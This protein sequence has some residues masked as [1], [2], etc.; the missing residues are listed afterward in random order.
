MWVVQVD[1]RC[2]SPAYLR[3]YV[4]LKQSLSAR[5]LGR[6]TNLQGLSVSVWKSWGSQQVQSCLTFI[7]GLG[8]WT[9]ILILP[10][11]CSHPLNYSPSADSWD[12]LWSNQ[13]RRLLWSIWFFSKRTTTKKKKSMPGF[14]MSALYLIEKSKWERNSGKGNET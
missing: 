12:F 2:S 1:A 11:K 9:Q 3:W 5:L 6:P 10:S 4:S 8:I 13:V 7:R 14:D